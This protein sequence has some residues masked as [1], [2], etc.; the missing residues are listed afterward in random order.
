[1]G[2]RLGDW[3]SL[4]GGYFD[5]QQTDS[6]SRTLNLTYSYA[7]PFDINM[8]LSYNHSIGGQAV[9]LAQF[10]LPFGSL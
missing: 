4:S 3:G 7:L 9:T 6:S 1:M 10:S 5:I 8:S 2:V